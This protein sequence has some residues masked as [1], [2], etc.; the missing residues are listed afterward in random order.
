MTM[1][2]LSVG[3][4]VGGSVTGECILSRRPSAR[5]GRG[6]IGAGGRW[7]LFSTA[8]TVVKPSCCLKAGISGLL[9]TPS[10]G[11]KLGDGGSPFL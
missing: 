7:L 3:L 1:Y 5:E 4:V 11:L 6:A 2:S 8:L 10:T 9:G